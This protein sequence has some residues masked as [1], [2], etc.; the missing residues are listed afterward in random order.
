MTFPLSPTLLR[1]IFKYHLVE[2]YAGKKYIPKDQVFS[3]A[4]KTITPNKE[5]FW[6]DPLKRQ[7][8]FKRPKVTQ[9]SYVMVKVLREDVKHKYAVIE[10]VG[11]EKVS[12][13]DL[14]GKRF[15][16]EICFRRMTGSSDANRPSFTTRFASA[17][18]LSA[19]RRRSL[20]ICPR[21]TEAEENTRGLICIKLTS[22]TNL[23]P[24]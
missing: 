10:T 15:L 8:T 21:K 1:N 4:G 6:T 18:R 3:P 11:L 12:S 2:R 16:I 7:F 22:S 17:I 13:N 19:S 9:D 20:N 5:G 23:N 24:L 14:G